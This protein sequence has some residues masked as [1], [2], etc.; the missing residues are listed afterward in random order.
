MSVGTKDGEMRKSLLSAKNYFVYAG[1]FSFFINMLMLVPA[2]YMLQVYDRVIASG[3]QSTLLMLTL[4]MM[5][6]F[7][8][9]GGLELVRSRILVRASTYIDQLLGH[10]VFYASFKHS[11]YTGGR[12]STQALNDLGGVR[13]F[14]TGNG[15]FAFFDAP[16]VPVYL[17]LLGLFHPYMGLFGLF[18]VIFLIVLTILNEK[19]TGKLLKEANED[20]GVA[21]ASA[22]SN[23]RNAEV[24]E[25]M[26]MQ[27][28]FRERWQ[29]RQNNVLALQNKASDRAGIY[30][31]LSKT[32]RMM[33]QSL[34]LGLGAYL[35]VEQAVSPGM[36]IAGSILLGR[37]L[38]PI[39]QMIGAWKSFTATRVQYNRLEDLL[40]R[41]PEEQE[42][43][44]LPAPNGQLAVKDLIVAAPGSR[45]PLL[46]NINLTISVGEFVG[47]I[48]PS[49]S[50]KSTFAR[51]VLGVWPALSGKVRL[52]GADIFQWDR[53]ALGPYVGYLPQDIELFDGSISDNIA[54]FGEVDPDKVVAAAQAAGVHE[55]VLALPQGY[56]TV[57]GA[58]GGVL[59]GGQ[60]QRIGL[61]RALY[62]N[63]CL[64]VLD[65][66]NSN[67]DDI[68]EKALMESMQSI[69]MRGTTT[70]LIITHRPN[71]LAVTDKILVL[72]EGQVA[73]FDDRDTVFKASAPASPKAPQSKAASAV[74]TTI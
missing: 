13:Q 40:G 62:G 48:G 55:M 33:F 2:I 51:A 34:V 64:I 52:D 4:I 17:V 63:P 66:P 32:S 20:A 56:D 14:L 28:S 60:R 50:G 47:I 25:S 26:G 35:A 58:G 1:I 42:K 29:Q 7:I 21:A 59:S 23:L 38:A 73:A 57:I 15:L 31:T 71:I 53:E 24:I 69:K 19:S 37:A 54:R 70:V 8:S 45:E 67:L 44:P 36:M 61:A 18:A 41:V 10:R 27:Q 16:W 6:L 46:K 74:V 65:E 49:G 30:T 9:S 72:K 43:M 68:G 39:D 3:S 12:S 5:F 22:A 11:L